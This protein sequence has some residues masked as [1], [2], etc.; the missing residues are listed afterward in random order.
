MLS[1]SVMIKVAVMVVERLAVVELMMTIVSSGYPVIR[2]RNGLNAGI[3]I[4]NGASY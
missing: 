3:H 2:S 1:P 4:S